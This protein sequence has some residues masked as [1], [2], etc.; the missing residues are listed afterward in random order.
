[1]PVSFQHGTSLEIFRGSPDSQQ[2]WL[3]ELPTVQ[4]PMSAATALIYGVAIDLGRSLAASL[5]VGL[6]HRGRGLPCLI[7]G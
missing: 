3:S 1:M 5:Y 4:S 6:S 2:L 7:L